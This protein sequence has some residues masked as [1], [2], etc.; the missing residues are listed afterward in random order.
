MELPPAEIHEPTADELA[1]LN[2]PTDNDEEVYTEDDPTMEIVTDYIIT[3]E[4]KNGQVRYYHVDGST[5]KKRQ[6]SKTY[7]RESG[8]EI[9]SE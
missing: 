6:V 8:L 3:K 4:N 2:P 5:N 9:R 1:S 7:A